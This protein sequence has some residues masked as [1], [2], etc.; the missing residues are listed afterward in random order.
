MLLRAH[1]SGGVAQPALEVGACLFGE[2]EG[3]VVLEEHIVVA[4]T[5]RGLGDLGA[6]GY[7]AV[8]S[9]RVA[10]AAVWP[11]AQQPYFVLYCVPLA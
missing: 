1:S 10:G 9:E 6:E 4:M 7:E 8:G 3:A 5:Q 11:L 2:D